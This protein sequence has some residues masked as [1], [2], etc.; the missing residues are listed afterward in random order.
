MAVHRLDA[1]QAFRLLVSGSQHSNRNC[2]T[3]S[4][5]SLRQGHFRFQHLDR[6][7]GHQDLDAKTPDC[8]LSTPLVCQEL[9]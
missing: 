4:V 2:A 8:D 3:S 7:P 9:G 6:R 1:A 5:R